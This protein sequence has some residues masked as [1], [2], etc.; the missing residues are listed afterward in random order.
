[1]TVVV[2]G[3]GAHCALG[4]NTEALWKAIEKGHSGIAAI[5]RF[6]VTPF[7][8]RLGAMVPAGDGCDSEAERLLAYGRAAASET[9]EHARIVDRSRVALV[10]GTCNGLL[11]KEVHAVGTDLARIL[12]LGGPAITFSTACASSAHAL[13]FAADMIRRGDADFALTGG[14]DTLCQEV[15]A[16][17]HSLRLLSKTPCAPFSTSIGTT[18]GE[19]AGFMLLESAHCAKARAA[20]PLAEFMGYGLSADAFHDT[21]PDPS[22]SGMARALGAALEDAG[23][24]P[25]TIDYV[26]AHGTGT[27][28]NDAAEWRAIQRV[29]GDFADR[30]PVSSSKSFLGHAQG[31]AGALEAVVTLL[32]ME[33]VV[34][35]PT[36]NLRKPRPNS[37]TDP[38]A[39]AIPRSHATRHAMCANSAFGGV[40]AAFVLGRPDGAPRPREESSR[41]IGLTGTG[42]SQDGTAI[43]RFVPHSELRGTDMSVRLLASAVAGALTDAGYQV[44]TPDCEEMGL[45][46]GQIRVS[47]GSVAAF[48]ESVHERGVG[49]VSAP[50][51]SRMVC[52]YATGACCRFFGLKGPVATVATGAD[53]GLT[54][55]V[56]G[57]D[58][59]AWRSHFSHLVAASVD[60]G[61]E[62]DG[63]RSAAAGI[64]LEAGA[65]ISPVMLSGWA[66]G[67]DREA[68]IGQ[69]LARAH[70]SH[71][72]VVPLV[73]PGPP[74]SAGLGGVIAAIAAL[75]EGEGG[76]FLISNRDGG[77]AGAAVI[78]E[79]GSG[80]CCRN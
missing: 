48:E 5:N 23:L 6:S 3:L 54:A 29:F 20:A 58:H 53:S 34:V 41:A 43:D 9:L 31:A 66:L 79:S 62:F 50:A 72:E 71:G 19:G 49:H 44:R 7:D 24:A 73:V 52:N 37:P 12:D 45:F 8:T 33:H 4:E 11:G 55:L 14:V 46:V 67:R 10:L 40:N 69:A 59:L 78:V 21:T 65:G 35:P 47:P 75:G 28:A 30:L 25:E 56:L 13:G 39:A 68:A 17:F 26:N 61:G 42:M 32:A 76:P 70:L 36:I 51:F 18:L 64:L 22:G 16:G 80:R 60:E 15:F 74:V 77:T 1:M 27:A 2:T 57:A 63:P 38:V